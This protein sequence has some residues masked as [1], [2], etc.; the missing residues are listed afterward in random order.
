M[1]VNPTN[2]QLAVACTSFGS[3]GSPEVN[4]HQPWR[5][6]R[7]T[8][9]DRSRG[10]TTCPLFF[11]STGVG[12]VGWFSGTSTRGSVCN[13][14]RALLGLF[15][16]R[17]VP[18]LS[19]IERETCPCWPTPCV[20]S[21]GSLPVLGL[22]LPR[23]SLFQRQSLPCQFSFK[24]GSVFKGNPLMLNLPD[25]WPAD[26]RPSPLRLRAGT[27]HLQDAQGQLSKSQAIDEVSGSS[28]RAKLEKNKL[29][30]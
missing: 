11:E 12:D 5:S 28:A 16:K 29:E 13:G 6:R 27:T 30:Q 18:M 25:Y 22:N 26:S 3:S 15:Q 8:A 14:G 24:G 1:C 7:K 9:P 17:N 19:L 2:P 23:L 20:C 21:R 10:P 4:G